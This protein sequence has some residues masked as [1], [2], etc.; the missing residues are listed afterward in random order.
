MLTVETEPLFIT[1]TPI[2]YHASNLTSTDSCK[3]SHISKGHLINHTISNSY[4]QSKR[5]STFG[6]KS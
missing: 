1:R 2:T 4:K 6:N 5:Y 3:H